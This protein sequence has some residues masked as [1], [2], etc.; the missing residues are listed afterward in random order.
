MNWYKKI[1]NYKQSQLEIGTKGTY[2]VNK[3]E[4]PVTIT[5]QEVVQGVTYW[6]G[7]DTS[8]NRKMYIY[9]PANFKPKLV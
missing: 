5:G 4:V 9:T 1:S 7:V 2:L 6:V 3:V 8:S